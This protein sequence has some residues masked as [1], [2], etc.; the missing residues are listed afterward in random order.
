[1]F[2]DF[3]LSFFFFF[4]EDIL[5][6]YFCLHWVFVAVHGLSLVVAGRGC[7]SLW[8]RAPHWSA[9]SHCRGQAPGAQVSL[10]LFVA[11][12]SSLKCLSRCRGQAP[13]AQVSLVLFVA[14]GSSLKCL[15]CRRGQAPGA[16]VSL[17]A[18]CTLSSCSLHSR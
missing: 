13:G 10:V 17:V 16:Q 14:Q 2:S 4:F 15:S 5:N 7:S 11:Q 12:G 18:A 3:F 6:T 9:F 8:C 1:M